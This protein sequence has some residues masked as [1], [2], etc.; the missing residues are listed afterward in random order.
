VSAGCAGC[1]R[2]GSGHDSPKGSPG[3]IVILMGVSGSGKTTLGRLLSRELGWSLYEGDEF[4]SPANVEKMSRGIPLT[5]ADRIPWLESLRDLIDRCVRRGE[6]AV[7]ACSALKRSY[8]GILKGGHPEVIFVHLKAD[9]R[10][11]AGRLERRAGHFAAPALLTSQLAT[12]E[13]PERALAIDVSGSPQEIVATIRR[14][15]GL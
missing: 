4:H 15:L 13:E 6:N 14:R 3:V 11:I 7:I 10:L 5:D 2:I 12:L 8:R 9:P 1:A